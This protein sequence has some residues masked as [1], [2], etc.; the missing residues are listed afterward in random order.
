MVFGK[1]GWTFVSPYVSLQG[2][3][4]VLPLVGRWWEGGMVRLSVCGLWRL[5]RLFLLRGG[6]KGFG[7][8]MVCLGQDGGI[9][10]GLGLW[11][12]GRRRLG[13][14]TS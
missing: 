11:V 1:W 8:R 6:T 13:R 3:V 10:S 7:D 9:S 12:L 14:S 5:Q 2:T 4:V